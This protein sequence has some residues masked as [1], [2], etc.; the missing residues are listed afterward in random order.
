MHAYIN[1]VY[2]CTFMY[3]FLTKIYEYIKQIYRKMIS[4]V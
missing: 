4:T 2:L 3:L 1:I